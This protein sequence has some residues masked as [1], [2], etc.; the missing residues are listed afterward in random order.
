MLVIFLAGD[1][2]VERNLTSIGLSQHLE[3]S[4]ISKLENTNGIHLGLWLSW[5]KKWVIALQS[6]SE[7]FIICVC[8]C[9]VGLNQ[10]RKVSISLMIIQNSVSVCCGYL[11]LDIP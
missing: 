4:G 10:K 5:T 2:H 9:V 11:L 7:R 1:G 8:V 3:L 6:I